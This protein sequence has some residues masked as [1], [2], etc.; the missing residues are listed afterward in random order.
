MGAG[1]AGIILV[2]GLSYAAA[3]FSKRNSPSKCKPFK[4]KSKC[5]LSKL[6]KLAQGVSFRICCIDVYG[7]YILSAGIKQEM[8]PLTSQQESVL[9]SSDEIPSDEVKVAISDE[10][11][12][13]DEDKSI[14]NNDIGQQGDE[15]DATENI[16]SQ[17]TPEADLVLHVQSDPETPGS[18]NIISE[19]KSMLDSS[20]EAILLD[21]E[22]SS[23]AGAENPT[24]EDQDSLPNA[25][26]TNVSNL[27]NQVNSQKEDSLSSLSDIDA[28]AATGTV[29]V[30][31]VVASQSDSISDPHTVPLNDT[32]T[33]V[34]TVTEELPEVNGTPEDLAARSMSSISDIDTANDIESS[35][36]PVPESTYWSKDELN[37]NSQ[38]ELGDNGPPLEIP[39]VGRAFSSTGIPAP[40]ISFQVNSGK[41]LV[42]A[43]AD[44]VQCQAFAA[45]QVLKV[46]YF[47]L[48]GRPSLCYLMV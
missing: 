37:M 27:E 33:A 15:T 38:D 46:I 4:H 10:N 26:P 21:S 44:Q 1:V 18:E 2:V 25:E 22:S 47:L 32:G 6:L 13:K 42:P 5:R 23:L 34:S 7:N 16:T 29:T 41:I 45:L 14:E 31:V 24:S 36:S 30:G 43:A 17:N 12:L 9:L 3:S 11:N 20:S 19:S 39:N 8:Q 48:L 40:S 35:K 28:D